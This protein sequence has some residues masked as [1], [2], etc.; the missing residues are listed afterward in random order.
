MSLVLQRPQRS[1]RPG[2]G[3]RALPSAPPLAQRLLGRAARPLGGRAFLGRGQ[4]DAGLASLRQSDR[5]R[6]LG[7]S[8]AVLAFT[9]VFD[10]LAHELAG[11]CRW[12]PASTLRLTGPLERGL[13]W[14]TARYA[15]CGPAGPRGGRQ[16][17][18]CVSLGGSLRQ[19]ARQRIRDDITRSADRGH[20]VHASDCWRP[21]ARRRMPRQA[22]RPRRNKRSGPRTRTSHWAANTRLR[23]SSIRPCATRPAAGGR[24]A[25][26]AFRT[27]AACIRA[28]RSPASPSIPS[29][30]E[31][32]E[33]T[34]KLTPE[35]QATDA[36]A[37][38][39]RQAG[40]RMGSD[41]DVRPAG[42]SAL[43]DRALPAGVH[44]HAGSDV[45]RQRDGQ[46]HPSNLYRRPRSRPGRRSLSA[47][48]TG[49]RSASG[50][51]IGS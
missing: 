9:N 40:H 43:A 29:T 37:H 28:P 50:T 51:A 39:G 14:H 49:I 15:S 18:T 30:P 11:L 34:A 42:T 5:N 24:S 31:G 2:G 38:R 45:A 36:Q 7:R 10:L 23:R 33:P 19:S 48:T 35:Y 27:G 26:R 32:G 21:R 13:P 3:S 25:G 22:I 8:C 17:L 46:R 1:A 4:I 47:R 41:L 16:P 12:S 44:R 6:L 20:V